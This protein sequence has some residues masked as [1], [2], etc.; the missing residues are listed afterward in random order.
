[1]H[2][3]GLGWQKRRRTSLNPFA[4]WRAGT[5]YDFAISR[6]SSGGVFLSRV[7]LDR[8]RGRTA[9]VGY[10]VRTMHQAGA[11]AILVHAA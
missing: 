1:L 7:G 8:I 10:W 5:W 3:F 6:V 9:N 4:Q 11:I 2:T